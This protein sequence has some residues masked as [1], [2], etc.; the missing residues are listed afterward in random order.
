MKS[1]I[2]SWEGD[3]FYW[4][5]NIENH[6]QGLEYESGQTESNL[7]FLKRSKWNLKETL[8]IL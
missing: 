4:K 8:I 1:E 2:I 6:P 3:K 5:R 7:T